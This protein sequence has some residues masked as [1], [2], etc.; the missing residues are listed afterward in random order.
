[1]PARPPAPATAHDVDTLEWEYW[2]PDG[3]LCTFEDRRRVIEG[4]AE[5]ARRSLA[6]LWSDVGEV[7]VFIDRDR[8]VALRAHMAEKGY[9]E[10]HHLQLSWRLRLHA[11]QRHHGRMGVHELRR[12]RRRRAGL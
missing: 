10:N 11:R 2:H 9:L 1:M 5:G 12:E 4:G 6:R 3:R 7:G 8:L